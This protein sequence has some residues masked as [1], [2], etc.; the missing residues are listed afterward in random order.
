MEAKYSHNFNNQNSLGKP[1]QSISEYPATKP[2]PKV[3]ITDKTQA[4]LRWV[5]LFA[6]HP[7]SCNNDAL[8]LSRTVRFD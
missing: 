4:D 6:Y 8:H 1:T 5:G 3:K 7:V 2:K